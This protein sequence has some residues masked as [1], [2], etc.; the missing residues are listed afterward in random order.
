[1]RASLAHG[2]AAR[3]VA[4]QHFYSLLLT[5]LPCHNG[6]LPNALP[7][8]SLVLLPAAGNISLLLALENF[9]ALEIIP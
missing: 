2:A 1:M 9:L 8:G 6:R 4:I 3:R 7:A 5:G